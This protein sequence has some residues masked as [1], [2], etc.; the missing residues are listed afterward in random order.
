MPFKKK[1]IEVCFS[2]AV[3]HHFHKPDAIVVVTD[4]LRAASAI[5]TAF[6]NGAEKIIP[7][8][9]LEEAKKLKKQGYLIAAERD[10]ITCEFADFGN[11]P[12]NFTKDRVQN[13]TIVY[14]TTNGTQAIHKAKD[15]FSL[16]IGSFLNLETL[17]N[18]LI[19]EQR[20]IVILCSGWRN[21]FSLED[22]IFSGALSQL[23]LN[24]K[25][26]QTNCDSTIAAC[27]LW[28][29]ARHDLIGYIQKASHINRLKKFVPDETIK[30]CHTLNITSVIPIFDDNS[31]I[32]LN[33][34]EK[35]NNF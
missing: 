31:L 2:P 8:G 13:K 29:L 3:Y 9:S 23:L 20:D 14:S 34:C 7:V 28:S 22:T 21:R 27:D 5:C 11:S 4:I 17:S 12:N 35:N 16:V 19:S 26:F 25:K 15:C 30:Y 24:S 10:G 6:M 33:Y 18:W 32:E 1:E